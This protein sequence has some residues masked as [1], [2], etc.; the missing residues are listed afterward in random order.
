MEDRDSPPLVRHASL[1][2]AWPGSEYAGITARRGGELR[3]P[4][5]ERA[6]ILQRVVVVAAG[7]PAHPGRPDA[8][9]GTARP[10]RARS[11]GVRRVENAGNG[12][13]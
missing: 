7:V 6:T 3:W 13:A 4:G 11:P 2:A 9:G 12:E 1:G 5:A 10:D 8:G